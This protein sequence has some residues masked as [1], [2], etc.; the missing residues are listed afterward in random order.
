MA[1]LPTPATITAN[2]KP[3]A[4]NFNT[5][6]D[7]LQQL[8]GGTP[9]GGQGLLDCF[10]GHATA[11]QNLTNGVA[12]AILLDTEDV[13]SAGGHSTSSNTSRYVA[14]TT[15]WHGC[16]GT[17]VLGGSATTHSLQGYFEVNGSS[18][19]IYWFEQ[20]NCP[21][22]A[23]IASGVSFGGLVFLTAAD[24]IEIFASQDSGGTVA[25]STARGGS[26]MSVKWMHP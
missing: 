19:N 1:T 25:T 10:V 21:N 26:R 15:G 13:D 11:T 2:T 9:S 4:A 7:A 24:Y 22:G 16:H 17:V 8:Q 6:R 20:I 18:S 5:Y 23:G 12:A 14:Q 3:T